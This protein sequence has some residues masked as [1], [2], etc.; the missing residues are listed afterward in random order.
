MDPNKLRIVFKPSQQMILSGAL[1]VKFKFALTETPPLV[2]EGKFEINKEQKQELTITDKIAMKCIDKKE[3]EIS[4]KKR[5]RLFSK[6]TVDT[7]KFKIPELGEKITAEKEVAL[8]G[9][10]V[11]FIFSLREPVRKKEMDQI[12]I[13]KLVIDAFP[14]PFRGS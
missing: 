4:L 14:E 7:K 11:T 8:S 9:C 3:F 5:K 1:Y 6:E 2:F 10:P 12:P 13:K